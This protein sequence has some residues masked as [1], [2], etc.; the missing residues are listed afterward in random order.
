MAW[1]CPGDK[2]LSESMMFSLLMH[3]CVA[4]PQWVNGQDISS[5]GIA[6]LISGYS[7]FSIR[8]GHRNHHRITCKTTSHL[9]LCACKLSLLPT[10]P[11]AVFD[12]M[13]SAHFTKCFWAHYTNL[14]NMDGSDVNKANL[15]DLIA[16]TSLVTSNWIQIV[17]FSTHVTVKFDG[18]PQKR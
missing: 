1:C 6:L 3:L 5:H 8:R 17:I 12:L 14:I 9:L 18:W 15:R 13:H 4:R 10:L 11:A 2:P 16:A 7:S